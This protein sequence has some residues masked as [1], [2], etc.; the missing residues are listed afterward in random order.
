MNILLSGAT[1]MIG[2]AI[3]NA[4]LLRGD[5][6]VAVVRRNCSKLDR[7]S[8]SPGLTII[9]CDM[10]EYC[11]LDELVA[12]EIDIAI[13]AAWGGTR[14]VERDDSVIQR[15]NYE[16]NQ[17]FLHVAAKLGCK[18][19]LTSGSQA[20]YGLWTKT[21]K[22]SE[23]AEAH[24]ITEYGKE[25]LHF[26]EYSKEFCEKNQIILIEPRFFSIYGPNDYLGTFVMSILS[27]MLNNETCDMTECV[28][29]WDFL[30]ID[31]AVQAVLKLIDSQ[32]AVGIYNIGSGHSV[33]LKV[34]VDKMYKIT[35]SQSK[36]NYGSVTYPKIG[37]VNTNPSV[38]K[39]MNLG[40]RPEI[41]F[42]DGINRIIKECELL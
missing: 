12:I 39:L 10:D 4:L 25:K 41:D 30:Y 37:I 8:S 14:G 18:K 36:L 15:R 22:I 31:D 1:S 16:C 23:N 5:H 2:A 27:K 29:L 32:E 34:Y 33:P 7:L 24:P 21:E 13:T 35:K 38:E 42:V 9:E 6:V 26:Y 40:W 11:R 20:E 19:F 3:C 28:Q 17:A